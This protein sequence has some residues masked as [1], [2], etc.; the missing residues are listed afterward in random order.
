MLVWLVIACSGGDGTEID[1]WAPPAL[2]EDLEPPTEASLALEELVGASIDPGQVGD[3]IGAAQDATELR[4]RMAAADLVTVYRV[5]LRAG[6]WSP[7]AVQVLADAGSLRSLEQLDAGGARLGAEGGRIL[8]GASWLGNVQILDLDGSG[9]GDDGFAG[10]CQGDLRGVVGLD[11][12]HNGL[13][14]ASIERFGQGPFGKVERVDVSGN[15]LG[16][17][18]LRLLAASKRL[19]TVTDLGIADV[20]M[21]ERG[22]FYVVSSP[23]MAGLD[24]LDV[25]GNSLSEA[26]LGELVAAFGDDAIVTD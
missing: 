26:Q 1:P 21:G 17:E 14:A 23:S 8:G 15:A 5:T 20:S 2:P 6:D 19:D 22:L 24:R 3:W 9:L 12:S 11:L 18:G 25:R 4:R 7:E 10:L 13:T 16:D